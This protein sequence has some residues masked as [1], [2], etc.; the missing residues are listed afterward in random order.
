MAAIERTSGLQRGLQVV[1]FAFSRRRRALIR[2]LL[3]LVVFAL[4]IVPYQRC[5]TFGD[6]HPANSTLVSSAASLQMRMTDCA[7]MR[8]GDKSPPSPADHTRCNCVTAV[9]ASA[10]TPSKT[11]GLPAGQNSPSVA[12]IDPSTRLLAVAG[13]RQL[14]PLRDFSDTALF[15]PFDRHVVMLN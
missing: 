8:L 4:I 13:E 9:A 15:L 5:F 12:I 14:P 3:S 7:E 1:V 2:G 11:L 10:P 6:V